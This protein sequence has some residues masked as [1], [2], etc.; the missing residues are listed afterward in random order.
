MDLRIGANTASWYIK[1]IQTFLA[2]LDHA[3]WFYSDFRADE[4]LLYE[5]ESPKSGDGRGF[6][7]GRIWTRD[8]KLVASTA[9]EGV[10]RYTQP[11]L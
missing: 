7:S 2:S 9:Q 1:L 4:W 10:V 8:G 5:M 11:K 3:I 6:S